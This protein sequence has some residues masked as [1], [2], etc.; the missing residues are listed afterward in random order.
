MKMKS[1]MLIMLLFA[2]I[3]ASTAQ[4]TTLPDACGSDNVAFQVTLKNGQP[5]SLSPAAGKALIVF[6]ETST[7]SGRWTP[8]GSST[9]FTVRFGLDGEWVG[10]TGNKSYF[11]VDVAPGEHHLCVSAQGS[12]H[13]KSMIGAKSFTAEAGKVYFYEFKIENQLD[14]QGFNHY[15]SGFSKLDDDEGSFRVKAYAVSAFTQR[16]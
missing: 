8:F 2:G 13:A 7:K 4:A 14:G 9:D 15:S 10:A 3:F 12:G 6:I 1:V 11:T 16:P 5:A